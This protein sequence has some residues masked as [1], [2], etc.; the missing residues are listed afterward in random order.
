V[1]GSMVCDLTGARGLRH[2]L[3]VILPGVS[4]KAADTL[5]FRSSFFGRLSAEKP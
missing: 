3:R 4:I 5:D 1:S 2:I